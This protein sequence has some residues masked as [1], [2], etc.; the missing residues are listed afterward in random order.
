MP[1][2]P[3]YKINTAVSA[4]IEVCAH[5]TYSRWGETTCSTCKDGFL[6]PQQSEIGSAWTMSCP[7]GSWCAAGVQTKCAAGKFGIQERST[8][9]NDC[10]D[11]PPGYNCQ[12]GTSDFELHPCPK[13][14]Y[15]PMGTPVI[16]C[17]SGTFNNELYGRSLSDCKTCP[18]GHQCGEESADGG[19]IC[20]KGYYCPRGSGTGSYPCPAGTHGN[21]QTGKKDVNECSPCPPGHYCPEASETPTVSPIGYYSPLS[22]LPSL[23][24]LY[25][26]PPKHHCPN[27]GMTTYKGYFCSAGYVC[28]AASTS[29]TMVD[30]PEGS[31]SDREDL[32]DPKHC[33]I[34]PKG[35]ACGTHFTTTEVLASECPRHRYCPDA[36]KLSKIPLCPAGTY[37]PYT[38]S[39][40]QYDCLVCP[41]GAYCDGGEGVVTTGVANGPQTCPVGYY[42]PPGTAYVD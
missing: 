29:S 25:K 6:C 37:A 8:S 4:G 17:P 11:C 12:P 20:A 23:A 27:T 3:G 5:K 30:C 31:F 1:V 33:D 38:K 18:I 34:C 39:K 42:C 26:C 32:H 28:P 7:R 2:P 9:I 24:A 14:G 36:T 19:T 22:G 15:C 40:S 16:A 13:G 10:A 41:A 35:Y 21:A